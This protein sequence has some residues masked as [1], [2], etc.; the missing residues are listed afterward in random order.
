MR[1]VVA[2]RSAQWPLAL[3][4]GAALAGAPQAAPAP[5]SPVV[6]AAAQGRCERATALVNQGVTDKDAQA[7]F[8]GARML[9]EGICTPRNTEAAAHYFARAS[10]LGDIDATLELAATI[11]QGEGADP[12]YER[13]G[14]L[15][16]RAGLDPQRQLT[17][18]SLGYACT[19]RALA[20]R[21]ARERMPAEAL[22]HPAAPVQVEF[23]PGSGALSIRSMPAVQRERVA[24]TGTSIRRPLVDLEQTI[25]QA[26]RE[27]AEQAPKPDRGRLEDLGVALPIDVDLSLEAGRAADRSGTAGLNAELMRGELVPAGPR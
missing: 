5:P 21:L 24:P 22:Q 17:A 13:A 3:A 12:N 1:T 20:G 10:D 18:Y 19:L 8:W 6:A 15:C 27:A 26:W 25:E 7:V 16:R 14:E 4:L 2:S 9:Q 11:G 23:R